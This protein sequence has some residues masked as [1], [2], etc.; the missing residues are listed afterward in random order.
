M[1][2]EKF[3]IAKLQTAKLQNAV[4]GLAVLAV[5]AAVLGSITAKADHHAAYFPPEHGVISPYRG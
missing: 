4:V 5:V 2:Q 1:S 3:Q